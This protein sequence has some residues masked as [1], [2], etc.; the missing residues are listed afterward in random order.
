MHLCKKNGCM[1]AHSATINNSH[2]HTLAGLRG[3]CMLWVMAAHVALLP[4]YDAGFGM[5]LDTGIFEAPLQFVQAAVDIFIMLSGFFLYRNYQHVFTPGG[6]GWVMD[7]FYLLR[8]ARL[9]PVHMLATLWIGLIHWQGIAHPIVSNLQ[10][11]M[12]QYWPLTLLLNITMMN[13]WGI[14]P[15][16]SWNEPAWT[17]SALW[18]VYLIF[19]VWIV[20]V[21]RANS[22]ISHILG[23]L[24]MLLLLQG[25]PLAITGLSMTDGFGCLLRAFCFF[26]AGCFTCRLFEKNTFAKLGNPIMFIGLIIAFLI[27]TNHYIHHPFP[28]IFIHLFY[29][30]FILTIAYAKGWVAKF[31]ACKPFIAL[32]KVS[33][34]FYL[35]HYPFVL[36][37]KHYF[38]GW[39]DSLGMNQPL[40]WLHLTLLTAA[41]ALICRPITM[42]FEKPIYQWVRQKLSAL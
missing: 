42:F 32:E 7:K 30:L 34:S 24:G 37:V 29:P 39:Y 23:I 1:S 36:Y 20:P 5:K 17:I 13:A 35:L 11:Q 41:L 40:L 19:P 18:F 26:M 2:L 3:V 25:L 22:C 12:M 28:L 38:G 33:Y 27:A 16:A 10:D 8:F 4:A 21:Q 31:M 9:W 14:A 6:R 15:V